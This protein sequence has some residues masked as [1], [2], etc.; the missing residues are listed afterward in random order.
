MASGQNNAERNDD[1]G[2]DA[3]TLTLTDE[4]G[5]SLV[6]YI[7][8]SLEVEGQEY[9]LLLPVDAPVEIFAWE[10]DE[11]DDEAETLV[12]IEDEEI[13]EV[14]STA[15]AVMAEQDLTLSRTALTLTASGEIPPAEEDDI[16]T[17]DIEDE[18]IPEAE[19]EQF[20]L[21][22]NF[23]FEEQEY[24][25]CTPLDPL[26]FFARMDKAGKPE[27]LSPAEFQAIRSQLEDQLF[28]EL[29]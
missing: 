2:S 14:F 1:H 12:D 16:I 3:P 6:C 23:F 19:S 29:E 13:D 20:Q 9:V 25:I 17:L 21:L 7:E 5:R 8:H 10:P 27:L 24:A 28:D 11:E 18:G 26:L 15:R 4:A 22:G